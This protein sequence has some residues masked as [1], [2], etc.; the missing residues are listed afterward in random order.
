MKKNKKSKLFIGMCSLFPF[1]CACGILGTQQGS[2]TNTP[3][4]TNKPTIIV[5]P[6]E[7][8]YITDGTPV[9]SITETPAPTS[10]QEP[11]RGPEPTVFDPAP[12]AT[13][14]QQKPSQT[15]TTSVSPTESIAPTVIATPT[16]SV[17]PTGQATVSPTNSPVPTVA[18]QSPSDTP[19]MTPTPI[20][21]AD[22]FDPLPLIGEGWQNLLDITMKYYVIFPN[23]FDQCITEK[24]DSRISFYYTSSTKEDIQL[25]VSYNIEQTYESALERVRTLNGEWIEQNEDER[26][27]TYRIDADTVERGLLLEERYDEELLGTDYLAGN[28]AVGVMWVMFTYPKS[29]TTQYETEEYSFYVTNIP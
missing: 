24:E 13:P 18:S 23:C 4:L 29:Q 15:P 19:T 25:V 14:A 22:Q 11:T 5:S 6:T 21:V 1:L 20:E 10:I 3:V 9:T 17:L 28:G 26:R 7:P 12:T 2:V 8:G 27:A 16:E